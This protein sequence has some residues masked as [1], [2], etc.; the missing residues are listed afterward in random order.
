MELRDI[1]SSGLETITSKDLD[2]DGVVVYPFKDNSG[3]TV[4]D[5]K[6]TLATKTMSIAYA[7]PTSGNSLR[8]LLGENSFEVS[9]DLLADKYKVSLLDNNQLASNGIFYLDPNDNTKK[10]APYIPIVHSDGS[11]VDYYDTTG[12]Q[13]TTIFG[14]LSTGMHSVG[15]GWQFIGVETDS[16]LTTGTMSVDGTVRTNSTYPSGVSGNYSVS[17]G[18]YSQNINDYATTIGTG[19]YSAGD[20]T[21]V[22]GQYNTTTF[23]RAIPANFTVGTGTDGTNRKNGVVQYADGVVESPEAAIVDVLDNSKN[24]TTVEAV[25]YT[26]DTKINSLRDTVTGSMKET[27]TTTTNNAQPMYNSGILKTFIFVNGAIK[28]P[29]T[30]YSFTDSSTV[31]LQAAPA[32]SDVITSITYNKEVRT[33][34]HVISSG[35]TTIQET[36]TPGNLV[37]YVNGNITTDYVATDGVSIVFNSALSSGDTVYVF[38]FGE[39]QSVTTTTV[40]AAGGETSLPVI[41]KTNSVLVYKNGKVLPLSEYDAS[42]PAAIAL[43]TAAVANDI[44][45]VT[46]WPSE[47]P[48]VSINTYDVNATASQD[49]FDVDYK[50]EQLEVYVDG[51]L[52]RDTTYTANDGMHV[53][54]TSAM[55]GGEWVH[56]KAWKE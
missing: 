39:K 49:T 6:Y 42:N 4:G 7:D 19:L 1:L 12:T 22:L 36:Y 10:Y 11:A 45:I 8:V 55:S 52:V 18:S 37:V 13:H 23:N 53:V 20:N 21:T 48:I 3:N 38:D 26:V 9:S 44:F 16:R 28:Y 31:Y 41:H 32:I 29:T 14:D 24:L 33:I 51:T 5:I 17:F 34:K 50:Q 43:T 54:F 46:T 2:N 27:V 56:F 40:I 47:G 15:G 30:D 35:T 25:N